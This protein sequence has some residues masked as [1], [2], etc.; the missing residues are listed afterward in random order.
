VSRPARRATDEH[1][2]GRADTAEQHQREC[3]PQPVLRHQLRLFAARRQDEKHHRHQRVAQPQV[4]PACRQRQR[5][6]HQQET[7]RRPGPRRCPRP[8]L[9][10]EKT[11]AERA[12]ASVPAMTAMAARRQGTDERGIGGFAGVARAAV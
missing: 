12:K 4:T 6:R 1:A 11:K 9:R 10:R 7:A 8:M 2:H 3:Q 5:R